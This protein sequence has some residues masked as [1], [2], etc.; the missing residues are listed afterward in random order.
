[1]GK[2]T[3]SMS[4]KGIFF[5]FIAI[6]IMAVFILIYKPP[7]DISLSKDTQSIRTRIISVDG[8]VDDLENRYFET[9]LRAAT[10]KTILSLIFYINETGSYITDN[11]NSTF[12]EVVTNGSILDSTGEHVPIDTLTNKQIMEDNTLS[13]W[14]NTIIESAKDT[15]DVDTEINITNVTVFQTKPWNIDSEMTLNFTVKS[16]VAEWKKRNITISTTIS[17]EGLHDPYYLKNTIGEYGNIIN[18]S[19]VASNQWNIE[20]FTE[21]LTYGT[22]VHWQDSTAPDFLMRLTGDM[23][24][25]S[26]CC[27]IE[28]LVNPAKLDTPDQTESYIDYLFWDST[29][30]IPCEELYT[31]SGINSNFKLD[32]EH[33][34]M[35]RLDRLTGDANPISC[36]P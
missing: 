12:Y 22:Y 29:N 5:T 34:T 7:A 31:I 14:S 28:S 35:Y 32:R 16:N 10:Y 19:N 2:I 23:T 27:G 3:A 11:L 21:H 17:I 18:K 1:M 33:V 20:K 36:G 26:P 9:M 4:K 6:T 24:S 25:S 13:Y 30:N 8:Y 15:L